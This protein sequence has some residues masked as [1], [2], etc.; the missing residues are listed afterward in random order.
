[1]AGAALICSP[2]ASVI[3]WPPHW[4]RRAHARRI[5]PHGRHTGVRR[6]IGVH[7]GRHTGVRFGMGDVYPTSGL[8]Y[9]ERPDITVATS[10]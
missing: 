1:M 5:G 10:A 3:G 9:S 7:D 8:T 2:A 6:R 4:R